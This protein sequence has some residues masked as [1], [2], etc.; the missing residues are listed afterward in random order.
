[1][2]QKAHRYSK[3][4]P[5]AC[6]WSNHADAEIVNRVG[7]IFDVFIRL[8][9]GAMTVRRV[10]TVQQLVLQLPNTLVENGMRVAQN[11]TTQTAKITLSDIIS[12]IKKIIDKLAVIFGFTLPKWFW[13]LM[14]LIDEIINFLLS[15]GLIKLANTL[16]RRHQDFM[17]EMTH[18]KRLQR[19]V[20]LASNHGEDEGEE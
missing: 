6:R 17:S 11:L 3:R 5:A 16:S 10:D 7:R 9:I 2:N 12:L 1:M 4:W 8:M 20:A 13:P 18:L 15:L 19:E 14:E